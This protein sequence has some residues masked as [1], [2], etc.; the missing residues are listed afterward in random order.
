MKI[1]QAL[2]KFFMET[3]QNVFTKTT[4]SV[5]EDPPG[6]EAKDM[7]YAP[8]I[9]QKPSK[10]FRD[11]PSDAVNGIVLHSAGLY[12][13]DDDGQVFSGPDFIELLNLSYH[14]YVTPEGTVIRRV[15]YDKRARHAGKSEFDG[16][17]DLNGTFI[18]ICLLVDHR[19]I[20]LGYG[21][22]LNA[23][24]DPSRFTDEHY[25]AAAWL[26]AKAIQRYPE[27]TIDR[28]VEHSVVSGI[29]VRPD[30][31]PDPGAGF[32]MKRLRNKVLRFLN[33]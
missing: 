15:G 22:Y 9:I 28:I 14:D 27:I 16:Q 2:R 31:K 7:G 26:C 23:I 25:R 11:R 1:L 12:I 33:E 19:D 21:R 18:G 32:Y 30:P 5:Q 29:Q 4:R 24:K 13:Q 8:E 17:K 6:D 20:G 3:L 10:M